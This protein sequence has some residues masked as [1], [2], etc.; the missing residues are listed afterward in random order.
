V[1][2]PATAQSE[3]MN[4]KSNPS[5][6]ILRTATAVALTLGALGVL[7]ACSS[8]PSPVEASTLPTPE[9]TVLE[10]QMSETDSEFD[11]F[12]VGEK[13]DSAGD[14]NTS[15]ATLE[16]DGDVAGRMQGV[17]TTLD[18]AYEGHQCHLAIILE[19][20]SLTLASGGVRKAIPNVDGRGDIFA[21]TGGTGD[22]VG[23][24]GEMTVGED[25]QQLT[26]TLLG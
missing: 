1:K 13:G 4:P 10:F 7:S 19:G 21:V 22:Y 5:R 9:T 18:N 20:G 24:A 3:V 2:S 17:C 8:D 16:V 11:M 25:G 14:R 6:P 23:A 15:A 26:I 12:D